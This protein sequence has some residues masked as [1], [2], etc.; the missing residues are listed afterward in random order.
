MLGKEINMKALMYPWY[1]QHS[2]L[3]VVV[4]ATSSIEAIKR[5]KRYMELTT[6]MEFYDM[7][8]NWSHYYGTGIIYGH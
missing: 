6:G 5:M 1:T 4:L 2:D 7:D 3:K 8:F